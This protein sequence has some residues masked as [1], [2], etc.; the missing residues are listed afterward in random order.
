MV[1]KLFANVKISN[2]FTALLG[3][4]ILGF[5]LFNIHSLSGVTEGGILGLTLLLDHWLSLSPAF[6]GAVLNLLSYGMG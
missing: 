2:C 3:S 5:G 6:T 4:M 1:K